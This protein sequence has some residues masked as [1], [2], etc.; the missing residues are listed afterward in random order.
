MAQLP[1]PR[2]TPNSRARSTPTSPA[3]PLVAAPTQKIERPLPLNPNSIQFWFTKQYYLLSRYSVQKQCPFLVFER[4]LKFDEF[5]IV[6]VWKLLKRDGNLDRYVSIKFPNHDQWHPD[7]NVRKE[8]KGC[9]KL[10]NEIDHMRKFARNPHCVKLVDIPKD[11]LNSRSVNSATASNPYMVTEYHNR[12]DLL[13]LIYRVADARESNKYCTN[14]YDK[15]LEFIPNRTLWRILQCLV[16]AI[17]GMAHVPW[18]TNPIPERHREGYDESPNVHFGLHPSNVYIAD[19]DCTKMERGHEHDVF[20][21]CAL[22]G[23]GDTKEMRDDL[24]DFTKAANASNGPSWF[25]TA[26]E[27]R[28]RDRS[29]GAGAF[30]SATNVWGIGMIMYNLMTL[31]IPKAD[32]PAKCTVLV[33]SPDRRQPLRSRTVTSWVPWLTRSGVE[34]ELPALKAVDGNLRSLIARCLADEQT[35][36]P[37]LTE[38]AWVTRTRIDEDNQRAQNF[39]KSPSLSLE[40]LWRTQH[41]WSERPLNEEDDLPQRFYNNHLLDPPAVSDPHAAYWNSRT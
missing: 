6:T 12:L 20:P 22:G 1:T 7:P 11:F 33:R 21:G 18:T 2:S 23:Y 38:L 26:P 25:W 37:K 13:E 24:D 35:D 17:T 32:N 19:T 31:S 15:K 27:Q 9:V 30:D 3:Q 14:E 29:L 34:E 36:R 10:R 4:V 5:S 40:D 28:T 41:W 16:R 8:W 39:E